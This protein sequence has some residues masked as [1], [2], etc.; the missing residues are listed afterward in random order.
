MST[1]AWAA[2]AALLAG[3]V[4]AVQIWRAAAPRPDVV[5]TAIF[6]ALGEHR[7]KDLTG[8]L[9]GSGSG[10]YLDVA[11]RICEPVA[12]LAAQSTDELRTTLDRDAQRALLYGIGRVQRWAWLDWVALIGILL[13][14][15]G[16]ALEG[17]PSGVLA[18]EVLT[19]T[20]LWL[21]NLYGARST[22]TRLFAGSTALVDGLVEGRELL[23]RAVEH[24][25]IE[26]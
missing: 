23:Q 16:A 9:S 2:G 1:A 25:D 26:S 8:V 15:T 22:A 18:L 19:A 17:A 3:S 24:S 20:L 7:V 14:G 12:K 21:S 11:R 4:R 5:N 10:V 13:A 6:A